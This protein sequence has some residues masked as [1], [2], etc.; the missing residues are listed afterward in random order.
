M[1]PS[2]AEMHHRVNDCFWIHA[3]LTGRRSMKYADVLDRLR[4]ALLL[5]TEDKHAG[6][7]RTV[8]TDESRVKA[9]IYRLRDAGMLDVVARGVYAITER[10]YRMA[11][12]DSCGLSD[13]ALRC[14]LLLTILVPEG[15]AGN[16]MFERLANRLIAKKTGIHCKATDYVCDGGIDGIGTIGGKPVYYVQA[17]RY[18]GVERVANPPVQ[19]LVG[20][21]CDE[22]DT[23]YFVT[24]STFAKSAFDVIA[25]KKS[26]KIVPIDGY[27][28]TKLMREYHVGVTVDGGIDFDFIRWLLV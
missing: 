26:V 19:Q 16:R 11:E 22:V 5:T 17:K 23:G 10:G 9:A 20:C 13:E 12:A 4:A 1:L 15:A 28:V 8:K 6:R 21:C 3:E 18:S 25:A 7:K 27:E 14:R 24:T 2:P